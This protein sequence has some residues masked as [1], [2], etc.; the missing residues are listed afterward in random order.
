MRTTFN[1]LSHRISK[2]LLVFVLTLMTINASAQSKNTSLVADNEKPVL[3]SSDFLFT[4]GPVADKHGNIY[5]TDQP[6]DKIWKYDTE[7]N[8]SVFMEGTS[9]ANGLSMDRKGNIVACA[10]LKNEVLLIDK[11]KKITVLV[12]DYQGKKLNGPNDVWVAPDGGLFFTDPFYKR[13]YWTRTEQEIKEE[14]VYYLSP[15]KKTLTV[16][17]SGLVKP[18]GLVGTP[19][20]KTLYVAD[21][22]G[23]KTYAFTIG[24]NGVLQDKRVFAN[25]GSDGMTIDSQGNVYLTGRGVT[26]FNSKGEQIEK[27][28]IDAPWTANLCFGGKDRSTLFITASK[29]VFTVKMNVKGA[30]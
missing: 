29:S 21:I 11:N 17:A 19:D 3:I 14:N 2:H 7:G 26:I 28:P 25:M 20:G 15:D 18:N 5:F 22:D 13:D 12:Q 10:D 24:A 6:N 27:I 9:R 16:A 1:I 8:L 23:R 30:K 4:E